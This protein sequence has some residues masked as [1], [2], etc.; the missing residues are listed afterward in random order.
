VEA[1]RDGKPLRVR[2]LRGV[3][4]AA[5][6]FER[7]AEMKR[8]FLRGPSP[9][10]L[11]SETN[12]GDGI[13]MGMALGADLR[14]MN[15]AWGITVYKAEGEANGGVRAGISLFAQIERSHQGSITVNRYGER[16]GTEGADYD[17]SW[18]MF[19]TWENWLENGYRNM[20][21]WQIFDQ[22]CRDTLSVAGRSKDQPLPDWVTIADT[23]EQLAD[24]LGID[25]AGLT[26]TVARFNK[27]AAAGKDPEFHRGESPYDTGGT[28]F[29]DKPNPH[30]TLAPLG[31]GPYYAAEVAPG[32]LGT[33][34][35]LRVT[36]KAQV[37]DVFGRPIRRLYASGNSAG[38]GAPGALYGGYGGTLGP[39]MTFAYIAATELKGQQAPA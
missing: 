18:R 2:A 21:A 17:S 11:G 33:C 23:L 28:P 16:F 24:K 39:A 31:K 38:I 32:D 1:E 35:G 25:K 27:A 4:V 30:P 12:T 22:R 5:G 20:P 29:T 13:H 7:N 15:E 19:H 3:L 6:G 36:G 34:G 26:A 8:H 37:I 10:T 9:Y 14:N